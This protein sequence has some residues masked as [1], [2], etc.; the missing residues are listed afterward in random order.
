MKSKNFILALVFLCLPFTLEAS[1]QLNVY[2][3]IKGKVTNERGQGIAGVRVTSMNLTTLDTNS[4]LTNN[5]G[6]FQLEELPIGHLYLISVNSN[7]YLFTFS[8]QFIIL[9]TIEREVFF[10]TGNTYFHLP[11]TP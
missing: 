7:R 8:Y 9:D 2:G 3:Q 11:A 10:N 6:N 1:A 5:F 4:C